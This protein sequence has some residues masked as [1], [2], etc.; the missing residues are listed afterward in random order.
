MRLSSE[1]V[2]GVS[3]LSLSGD[4]PLSPQTHIDPNSALISEQLQLN[5]MQI[6][7]FGAPAEL[8]GT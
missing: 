2:V 4:V 6:L 5:Q 8:S 7:E 3:C 1:A